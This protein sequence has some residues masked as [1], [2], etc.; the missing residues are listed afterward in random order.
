MSR[1]LL[2]REDRAE[3]LALRR[4]HGLSFRELSEATGIALETLKGW[5]RSAAKPP[6]PVFSELVVRDDAAPGRLDGLEVLLPSG[7]LV[8]APRDVDVDA[9]AEVVSALSRPC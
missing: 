4:R 5:S 6:R 3:I 2:S 7:V 8:R 1:S 9:L